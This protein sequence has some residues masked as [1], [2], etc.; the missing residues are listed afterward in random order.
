MRPVASIIICTKNRAESL[1]QTLA[2]MEGVIV[3]E[4]EITELIIVDNGST[5]HT[6]EV[7]ESHKTDKYELNYVWE[8]NGGQAH[9]RNR[10]LSVAKSDII[11]FTDDDVLPCEHWLEEHIKG[12]DDSGIAAILGRIEALHI[13]P[14]PQEYS[15]ESMDFSTRFGDTTV[16]PFTGHLVGAN[17]S[18]RRSVIDA[19][20]GFNARLGPGRSGF[21]DDTD[22]SIRLMRAGFVQCFEPRASVQHVIDSSRLRATACRRMLFQL[23]ISIFVADEFGASENVW[24]QTRKLLYSTAGFLKYKFKCLVKR[25]SAKCTHVDLF[26]AMERGLERL[27]GDAGQNRFI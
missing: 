15:R 12:Y 11:V 22:F 13:G 27:Y 4:S 20:G 1:R 9:A 6:R 14:L 8:P 21:F 16:K 25:E 17:M 23:G 5:D 10:G 3:P 2:K 7:V 19:I 18:F 26:Y 24:T